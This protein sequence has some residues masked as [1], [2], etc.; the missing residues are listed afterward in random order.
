M[1]DL[2]SRRGPIIPCGYYACAITFRRWR[3]R[4]YCSDRCRKADWQAHHKPYYEAKAR[5]YREEA[6]RQRRITRRWIW[7]QE[8]HEDDVPVRLSIEEALAQA[9]PDLV[10]E[11][12]EMIGM[13]TQDA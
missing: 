11:I 1:P 8:G 2:K 12:Q 4:R 9:S 13:E 10:K 5:E 3:R 7:V 6:K